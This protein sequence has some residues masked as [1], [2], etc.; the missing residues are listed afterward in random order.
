MREE[1]REGPREGKRRGC[2]SGREG[3][4]PMGEI[5]K[6]EVKKID[7]IK[8][9]LKKHLRPIPADEDFK[10]IRHDAGDRDGGKKKEGPVSIERPSLEKPIE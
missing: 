9:S 8:S 4:E 3:S 2:M 7:P 6:G 10:G 5:E 1:K